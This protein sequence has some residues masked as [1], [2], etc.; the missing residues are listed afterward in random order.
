[1]G[2]ISAISPFLAAYLLLKFSRSQFLFITT[3]LRVIGKCLSQWQPRID[4]GPFLDQEARDLSRAKLR[5]LDGSSSPAVDS[6]AQI[7]LVIT[8]AWHSMTKTEGTY[9]IRIFF[10]SL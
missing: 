8:Q 3:P 4:V 6:L 9:M 2:V 5:A 10:R 7:L 1:V